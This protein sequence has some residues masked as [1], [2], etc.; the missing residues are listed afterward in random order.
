M[1]ELSRSGARFTGQKL[2]EKGGRKEN[3]YPFYTISLCQ[4]LSHFPSRF[5]WIG[6]WKCIYFYLFSQHF[7]T[8]YGARHYSQ[9]S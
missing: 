9:C 1:N 7:H 4:F 5:L 3:H 8:V 6:G 2:A